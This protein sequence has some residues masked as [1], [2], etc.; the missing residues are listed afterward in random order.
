MY[1]VL[2]ACPETLDLVPTGFD[3]E[4]LDDL[5]DDN[6]L[7]YCPACGA[8]HAWTRLEA[9]LAPGEPVGTPPLI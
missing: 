1:T 4:T 6:T 3:A 7:F 5:E 9:V 2:I 8:D